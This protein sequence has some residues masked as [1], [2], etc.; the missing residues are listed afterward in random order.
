[1]DVLAA[2]SAAFYKSL[3]AKF[4]LV[5]TDVADRDA[6]YDEKVN[7]DPKAARGTPTTTPARSPTC[8]GFTRRTHAA[9]S[10]CGRSRSA[11][12]CSTTRAGHYRDNRVQWWLADPSDGHLAADRDAGV[13][14]L[15]FGGGAGGTTSID[16]DGGYFVSR[17]KAYASGGELSLG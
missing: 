5:F 12:R 11:T 14:A 9:R 10:C 3:H 1:M 15:L 6:G 13:I 7:H 16:T 17:V 8:A 2:R 4:D